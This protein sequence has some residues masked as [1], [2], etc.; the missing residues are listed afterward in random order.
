MSN[1]FKATKG[2][3]L[4]ELLLV[5][6]IIAILA[7]LLLPV[8]GA[9]KRKAQRTAC[10]NNLRQISLG[11]RI[12]SDDS[13]DAS[14]SPGLAAASTNFVSLY[15]GYK[16]L[17]KNYVGVNGASSSQDKLFA[18]PADAFYPNYVL[19]N[20]WPLYYVRKSLHEESILDFSSYSFNGGDN[21]TPIATNSTIRFPGITGLKLS[22]IKHPTRTA[23]VVE[24]S[25]I[26]PWSWHDPSPDAIFNNA[27]S[28]V[29]FVDGHVSYI[30]IYWN[31]GHGMAC[32]Y[33][34]P[35]SY[36]YQWSGD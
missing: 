15:S 6:A 4:I 35:E 21:V 18:C 11:V 1:N 28:V 29:N 22:A 33:N 7:A 20:A 31:T 12:Y 10:L 13:N 2:F 3:T 9:A 5:I 16:Q 36:D 34:P 30:K 24:A 27:K 23:L 25:A 32:Y 8:L 26:G 14:P 19:T 17:M